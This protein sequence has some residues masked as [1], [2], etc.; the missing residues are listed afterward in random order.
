MAFSINIPVDS[1]FST[2]STIVNSLFP[3]YII[4]VG[5]TLGIGIL[6]VIVRAFQGVVR[7]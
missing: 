5:I 7:G 4:P 2:A 6:G 3:V 1:I